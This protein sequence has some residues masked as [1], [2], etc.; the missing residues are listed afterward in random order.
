MTWRT[1][2]GAS[3]SHAGSV[4]FVPEGSGTRIDV[5]LQY[6]PPGG[7]IAHD[8]A[9]LMDS[10]AGARIEQD[11]TEFKRAVEGGRLAA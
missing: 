2:P 5:S 7:A 11:L 8:V 6:D 10:D 1:A 9:P 4:R 3:V